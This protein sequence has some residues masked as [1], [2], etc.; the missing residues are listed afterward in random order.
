MSTTVR[1][2]PPPPAL[3]AADRGDHGGGGHAAVAVAS[4]VG[5]VEPQVRGARS[6]QV[7]AEQLGDVRVQVLR[8]RADLVFRQPRDAELLGDAL[9]LAGRRARRVHL[10]HRR[11]HGAVDALVALDDVLGEEAAGPQLGYAQ[12]DV[13]HARDQVALAVPVEAVGAARAQ[14]VGLGVHYGVDHVLGQAPHQLPQVYR[15]V[16]GGN[17]KMN[18]SA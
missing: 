12:P 1:P 6:A 7:P 9:H 11:H 18:I 8:Y 14:L 2:S 5:G 4:D 16:V 10:G 15:P 13:T 3:V 17:L